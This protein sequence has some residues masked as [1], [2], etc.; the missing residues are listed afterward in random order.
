MHEGTVKKQGRQQ[1]DMP[2]TET[3]ERNKRQSGSSGITG[4]YILYNLA[5]KPPWQ[6]LIIR[7]SHVRCSHEK[8]VVESFIDIYFSFCNFTKVIRLRKYLLSLVIRVITYISLQTCGQP[9]APLQA[10]RR[11]ATRIIEETAPSTS[12]YYKRVELNWN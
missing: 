8:R 7:W 3:K 2:C 9:P 10:L 4:G 1:S 6:Q 11:P 12:K 5:P